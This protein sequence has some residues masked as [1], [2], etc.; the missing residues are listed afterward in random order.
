MSVYAAAA[1]VFLLWYDAP[2]TGTVALLLIMAAASVVTHHGDPTGTGGIGLYLGM[3]FAPLRLDLRRA[4][5]VSVIAALAFDV[6]LAAEANNPFVFAAVVDGGAAFFFLL[7]VLL[8][9]EHEQRM[10]ADRLVVELEE[11]REAERAAAAIAERSRLAREMH[12]V[13]A[14]T[15][16]GLVLQLDGARMLARASGVDGEV[17]ETLDRAHGLARDGLAEARQA[18]LTLRGDNT[19]GPEALGAL[20]EQYAAT[21]GA[22]RCEVTVTGQPVDLPPDA[23]LTMYRTAQEALSNIA[24]HAHGADVVVHLDWR[25][26]GAT[27][28]IRDDGGHGH[29][30]LDRSGSGYGLTGLRERAELLGGRLTTGP[31]EAGFRVR[32]DLPRQ[33]RG[34]P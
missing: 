29:V 13:L 7:G 33:R 32:L 28:D 23:R 31:C 25:D 16:S 27:L 21:P 19:P 5:G 9:E 1:L 2:A 14:H 34:E 18:V 3:A 12:D 4:V 11:S 20:A 8:R 22:G 30:V 24:K 17:G 6:Q 10:R 15:L 26:D